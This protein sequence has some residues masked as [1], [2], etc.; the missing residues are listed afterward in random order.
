M[1]AA[2]RS[3]RP[4]RFQPTPSPEAGGN[5]SISPP[6]RNPHPVSTHPQPGGRGKHLHEALQLLLLCFNPPP[7]RRPGET[8]SNGETTG[9]VLFQ[10]TPSP[11]AGGNTI[12]RS[13]PTCRASF[14][15][16]P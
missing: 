16:T 4:S 1:P 9:T 7:A 2:A 12:A 10:P 11:E 15:P 3:V 8:S 6:I 5:I 13:L 14:Q